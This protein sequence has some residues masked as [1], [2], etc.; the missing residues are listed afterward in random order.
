MNEPLAR[1]AAVRVPCS[2]S[3]LGAGFDCLG[4]AFQRYLDARFT[5]GEAPLRVTLEGTLAAVAT[6][7]ILT[8]A[9]VERLGYAPR[10]ALYA[11]S[12]I[13]I[14]IGRASCRERV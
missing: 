6:P 9:F 13:P 2:T 4:L 10:G 1:P 7:D 14:E 5:P 8:A 12:S 11:T 3:N